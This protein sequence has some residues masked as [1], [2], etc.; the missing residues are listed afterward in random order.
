MERLVSESPSVEL[1]A[2]G[3]EWQGGNSLTLLHFLFYNI[4]LYHQRC[5]SQKPPRAAPKLNN[6]KVGVHWHFFASFFITYISTISSASRG[7]PLQAPTVPQLNSR[8]NKLVI[9]PS[10]FHHFWIISGY[11]FRSVRSMQRERMVWLHKLLRIA[12]LAQEWYTYRPLN[13][14]FGGVAVIGFRVASFCTPAK[15]VDES[16]ILRI[17]DYLF[18]WAIAHGEIIQLFLVSLFFG[19]ST[20]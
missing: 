2:T 13:I 9:Y 8:L 10:S 6:L 14:W 1:S 19:K 15:Y 4:S 5:L 7:S 3:V 17:F 18:L 11:Q 16:S 12:C 20:S